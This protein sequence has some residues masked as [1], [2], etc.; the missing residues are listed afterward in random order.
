MGVGAADGLI[1]IGGTLLTAA[2][3]RIMARTMPQFGGILCPRR[4]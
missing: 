2:L 4:S 1:W 3:R